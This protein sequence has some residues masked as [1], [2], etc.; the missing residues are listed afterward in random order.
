[1]NSEPES[2]DLE[3][4]LVAIEGRLAAIEMRNQRVESEKQWETSGS[5]KTLILAVTYLVM[6]LVFFS[7]N[8]PS[9]LL[10]AIVPTL[11]FFLSTLSFPF[12]SNWWVRRHNSSP[13]DRT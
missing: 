11:G 13:A 8:N 6:C 9:P 7:L 2:E 4:R 12:V 5:R 1:M 10:N 3:N